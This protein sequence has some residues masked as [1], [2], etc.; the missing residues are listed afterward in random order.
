MADEED[1]DVT[2]E[3]MQQS[4][5]Q[6][7]RVAQSLQAHDYVR[8]PPQFAH[9]LVAEQVSSTD[10]ADFTSTHM[11]KKM[12]HLWP[13]IP[14]SSGGNDGDDPRAEHCEQGRSAPVGSAQASG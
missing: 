1:K 3:Q 13:L 7:A 2:Y 10:V 8:A 5:E 14:G 11:L 4:S 9:S 6:Q 12:T